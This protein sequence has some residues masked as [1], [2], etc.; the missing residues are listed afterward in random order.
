MQLVVIQA[1]NRHDKDSITQLD[2]GVLVI[3]GKWVSYASDFQVESTGLGRR[4]SALITEKNK[5][6]TR[7][8]V[9]Y[10]PNVRGNSATVSSQHERYFQTRSDNRNPLVVYD[11]D[12][13]YCVNTHQVQGEGAIILMGDFNADVQ[14]GE[15]KGLC[16]KRGLSEL[17]LQ[18]H[19]TNSP[20]TH[21]RN[22]N[23]VLI[24][25][26]LGSESIH[27]VRGGYLG[28]GEAFDSNHRTLWVE[29]GAKD[30]LGYRPAETHKRK[31]KCIKS[32]DPRRVEKYVKRVHMRFE[33]K[34]LVSQ[35]ED[36]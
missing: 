25:E 33:K 35:T 29:I 14:A 21:E 28:F 22:T 8:M 3:R 5:Y 7:I 16:G 19:G 9:T 12:L 26:I 23:R 30:L 6:K 32:G 2:G 11:E 15:I 10:R 34:G 4:V 36:M 13:K 18:R 1:F 24:D 31:S 20:A 17:I 27:I